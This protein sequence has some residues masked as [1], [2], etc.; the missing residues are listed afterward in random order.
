MRHILKLAMISGAVIWSSAA[1]AAEPLV[2]VAWVKSNL[3]KDGIV[4]IDFRGKFGQ[5]H[6]SDFRIKIIGGP[7]C[8]QLRVIMATCAEFFM[9]CASL[10][11]CLPGRL[12][13]GDT[14]CA[15]WVTFQQRHQC[16][17]CG[18][19]L[20]SRNL[21]AKVPDD[22]TILRCAGTFLLIRQAQKNF[23]TG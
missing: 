9:M 13:G 21:A 7:V 22:G 8:V 18:G 20:V 6:F 14:R 12:G 2:D 11:Y 4:F 15:E 17:D 23:K 16:L 5:L 3:G 19:I 10:V 1:M